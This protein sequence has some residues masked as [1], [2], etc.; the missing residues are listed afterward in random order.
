MSRRTEGRDEPIVDPDIAIVD[1]HHHLFHNANVTYAASDYAE[2][3]RAGH[4]IVASVYVDAHTYYRTSGPEVLRPLGEVEFA[5]G[6]GAMADGGAFGGLRIC[7]AIVGHADLRLGSQV[8]WLLDRAMAAAPDRFRGIR[9]VT[10]DY[11][12][13][14]PY[15][16]FMSGLPPFG[17]L[18]HPDF[19]DGFAE[20]AARDLVFDAA[21]FHVRVP[22]LAK[23]ADAWPNTRIVLNNMGIAMALDADEARQREV[24]EEWRAN[25]VDI[26]RRDNVVCKVGG[27]GMPFWGFGLHEREGAIGSEELSRHWQPWVD[28]ALEAFGADR[29]MAGSNY[30]PDSRSA[31]FVPLWNALKR[32][33]A[34]CSADEKADL[35]SR[36]A[37]RT[38]RIALPEG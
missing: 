18:E 6:V 16:F 21:A 7:A 3:A 31:G 24:F 13:D 1:A 28:V 38:Y 12:D 30:P 11:P 25:L 8:G 26:A 4:R 10:M 20:L 23:L 17:V 14:T 36:T 29:C 37:A 34:G 22:E 35:F 32:T 33:V 15:R 27:L 5:N 9:Q 19:H 2:D